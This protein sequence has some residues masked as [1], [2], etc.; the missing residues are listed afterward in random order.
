MDRSISTETER[1][2]I[3]ICIIAL[4]IALTVLIHRCQCDACTEAEYTE[5]AGARYPKATDVR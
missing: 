3:V 4:W 5:W 2:V 1:A